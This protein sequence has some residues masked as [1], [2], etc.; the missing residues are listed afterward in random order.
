MQ[1]TVD[2]SVTTLAVL[3]VVL[4]FGQRAKGTVAAAPTPA[5][6]VATR[7]VVD[8]D[9]RSG[10]QRTIVAAGDSAIAAT[11]DFVVVLEAYGRTQRAGAADV[12]APTALARIVENVD[13]QNGGASVSEQRLLLNGGVLLR[14]VSDLRLRCG[15]E[16][17][18]GGHRCQSRADAQRVA[19]G[20]GVGVGP[21]G[22]QPAS[23]M[24]MVMTVPVVMTVVMSAMS[25]VTAVVTSRTPTFPGQQ[26][27]RIVGGQL[28]ATYDVR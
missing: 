3:V 7:I 22:A 15:D 11:V 14:S 5:A 26:R 19:V 25:V 1:A 17:R 28:V 8:G 21:T 10:A 27:V 9:G 2:S 13:G 4:N 20:I 23:V 12:L 6:T 24:M 16:R 18:G